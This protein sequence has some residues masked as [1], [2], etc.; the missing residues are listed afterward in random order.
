MNKDN[1]K[2]ICKLFAFPGAMIVLGLILLVSPD[3]AVV[4]V[5]KVLGW[6]LSILGVVGIVG[7][8]LNKEYRQLGKWV[9][10]VVLLGL[11]SY[12]L[13]NPMILSELVGRVFGILMIIDGIHDLRKSVTGVSRGLA[14]LTLVAGVVLMLLPRTLTQTIFSI[15][16]LV[17]IAVGV[18]NLLGKL[19]EYRYLEPGENRDIIDADE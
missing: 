19:R 12:V 16:G 5:T 15:C 14:I 9:G 3:S 10:P 2:K 6:V 11:G 4:L 13:S 17:M 7:I 18:V 1:L 8:F